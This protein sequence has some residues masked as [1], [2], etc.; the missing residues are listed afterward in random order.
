M[1]LLLDHI[2]FKP[3]EEYH[4]NDISLR[5]DSGKMYTILGRTLSGKTTLLKTIA[6]LQTPDSGSI[7]FEDTDFCLK[8]NKSDFMVVYFPE[9]KI[10]HFKKGSRNFLNY[11]SVEFNFYLSFL[12]F[13]LK[14]SVPLKIFLISNNLN[15]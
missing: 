13:I 7:N 4:L 14:F 12:K 2:S 5:F 10:K 9:A 11:I 6:G 1:S 8:L 15:F 3:T